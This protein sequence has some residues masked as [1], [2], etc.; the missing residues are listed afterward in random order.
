MAN[1]TLYRP[2]AELQREVDR[3]FGEF[4]PA[5]MDAHPS[6]WTPALDIW[7]KEDAYYVAVDLP[8]TTRENVQLSVE[9]GMLQ[10]SGERQGWQDER[11][12]FRRMERWHGRF[13]RALRLNHD[14]AT[15]KVQANFDNGVLTI[16]LPKTAES[17]PRRIEIK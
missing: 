11:Y 3:L 12:E 8:G 9:N 16:H 10:I 7:E 15:D 5:R 4:F 2:L 1:L 17:K 14:V 13:Y 6:V